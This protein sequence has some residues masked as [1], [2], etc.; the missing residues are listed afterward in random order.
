MRPIIT[1]AVKDF[2]RETEFQSL[3]DVLLDT[4]TNTLVKKC[5]GKEFIPGFDT[6]AK[7]IPR[8]ILCFNAVPLKVDSRDSVGSFMGV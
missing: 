8:L 1:L 6:I 7:D 5:F 3:W 4:F 2:P